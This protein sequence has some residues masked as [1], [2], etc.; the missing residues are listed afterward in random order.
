MNKQQFYEILFIQNAKP[1]FMQIWLLGALMLTKYR[2][3]FYE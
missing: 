2:H 1:V 3:Q